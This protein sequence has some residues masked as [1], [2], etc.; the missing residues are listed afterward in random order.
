[1]A[2]LPSAVKI[3]SIVTSCELAF[4]AKLRHAQVVAGGGDIQNTELRDIGHSGLVP[5]M[6]NAL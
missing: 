5:C 3:V 4:A 6:N 1:M 2:F